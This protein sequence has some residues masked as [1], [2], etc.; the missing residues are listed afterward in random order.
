MIATTADYKPR[1][2][3]FSRAQSFTLPFRRL[4]ACCGLSI[5]SPS[6]SRVKAELAASF[7][8]R[9]VLILQLALFALSQV[10]LPAADKSPN[11]ACLD[12]HGDKTLSKTNA[13][14][15]EISLFVDQAKF[16][17]TIHGIIQLEW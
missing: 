10:C 6:R 17:G 9:T 3:R 13:F 11:N 7:P 4:S 14:G 8:A 12:C 2:N 16:E 1:P 15:K 5:F